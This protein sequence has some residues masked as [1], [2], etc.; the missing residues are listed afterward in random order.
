MK[1]RSFHPGLG[2]SVVVI[3]GMRYGYFSQAFGWVGEERSQQRPGR[4]EQVG[5]GRIREGE[6]AWSGYNWTQLKGVQP[7]LKSS[8]HP[9]DSG[10]S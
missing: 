3:Q 2:W 10:F 6:Q 1:A 8:L 4:W 9:Q 5:S 7:D